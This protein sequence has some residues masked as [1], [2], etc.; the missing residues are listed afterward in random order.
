MPKSSGLSTSV[1]TQATPTLY[2][3]LVTDSH[4]VLAMAGTE[5]TV[6][7][8]VITV[9][10]D[11]G[12]GEM[13]YAVDTQSDAATDDLDTI[14]G[15]VT[16]DVI[17]LY[18]ADS[19]RV[20][21]LKH[22]TGNIWLPG[23]KDLDLS[24]DYS[25]MLRYDGSKWYVLGGAGGGAENPN[26][27][28]YVS[29][30]TT[31][32]DLVP[33]PASGV[34]RINQITLTNPEGS[35]VTTSFYFK[36]VRSSTDYFVF[37]LQLAPGDSVTIE[38]VPIILLTTDS[39]QVKVGATCTSY[40]TVSYYISSGGLALLSFTGNS[41]ADVLTVA[42][43]KK[44]QIL[45]ILVSNEETTTQNI[46]VQ[47]IDGSSN[48]KKVKTRSMPP[49][50]S[51]GQTPNDVIPAGYKYQVKHGAASKVGKIAISYQEV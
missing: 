13:H 6:A 43:G 31:Y 50:S 16:G 29:L 19:A 10:P 32:Q 7:T 36:I 30:T 25:V 33:A 21:K 23:G 46:S 3:N 28:G 26:L 18:L 8:G 37:E 35:G 48:V 38:D 5:K 1:K 15:G 40:A 51:W 41:Y 44:Y 22:N 45:S 11:L 20:V 42:T 39:I 14:N 17:S 27:Y 4:R 24:L 12:D 49:G 47:I 9:D 2:N 34:Y